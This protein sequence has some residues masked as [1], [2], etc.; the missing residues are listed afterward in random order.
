[1]PDITA[2]LILHNASILTLDPKLPAAEI[3]AIKKGI[4]M[5]IG[6]KN[7]ISSFRDS[8]TKMIDCRG[9]TVIPGFNDTHCHPISFA[10]SLVYVDCSPE[11]A[12]CVEDIVENIRKRGEPTPDGE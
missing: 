4:I 8:S 9:L 2:D 3:V 5:G 12:K 10:L 11:K 6:D 7:E 1:M